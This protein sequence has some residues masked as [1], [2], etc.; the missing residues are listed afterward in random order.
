ANTFVL[1]ITYWLIRERDDRLL[2]GHRTQPV[3]PFLPAR[4]KEVK[5]F[6]ITRVVAER[7]K[8]AISVLR[9]VGGRVDQPHMGKCRWKVPHEPPR[10]LMLAASRIADAHR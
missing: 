3:V 8:A 5:Y 9:Q 10:L 1:G 7:P 2:L 4:G 6:M